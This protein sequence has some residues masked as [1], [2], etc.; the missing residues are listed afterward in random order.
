MSATT[1]SLASWP[2]RVLGWLRG[3]PP[4][5]VCFCTLAI[6]AAYR[7]RARRLVQDVPGVPWVVMTDEPDDFAGLPVRATRFQPTGPM[8]ADFLDRLPPTRRGGGRPAYH[9]KRFVL[10]A[11]LA[12]F[13]SV[14]FVDADSRIRSAPRLPRFTSGIAV[15]SELNAS[16]AEHLSRWGQERLPAFQQL[17]AHLLGSADALRSARW[18]SEALFAVTRDGNEG[19]FLEAWAEAAELLHAREVFT[20]EGGVIG[21]AAAC[22][23]W[24][25]DYTRLAR[26]ASAT[27]HEGR[28]PK[29]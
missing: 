15:V 21:L 29:A 1:T 10:Q 28:G 23:G 20:G 3:R 11:A 7:E 12:E 14:I 2:S 6:H 24:T 19:R 22:A 8:A 26:L 5:S 18:C 17:A 16:I 27:E 4:Q 13:D 9:D 25:V